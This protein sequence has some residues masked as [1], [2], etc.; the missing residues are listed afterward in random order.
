M[1]PTL[2][3]LFITTQQLTSP[4]TLPLDLQLS[5][6]LINQFIQ[7]ELFS[8]CLLGA[9]WPEDTMSQGSKPCPVLKVLED[10]LRWQHEGRC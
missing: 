5:N 9:L 2:V 10:W 6:R 7:E 4:L 8:Q 1:N 3:S